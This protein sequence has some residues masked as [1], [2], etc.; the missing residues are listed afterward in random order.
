V[1]YIL[2]FLFIFIL[3]VIFIFLEAAAALKLTKLKP[4]QTKNLTDINQEQKE[5]HEIHE[6]INEE[7]KLPPIRTL[8]IED[9]IVLTTSKSPLIMA[10]IAGR[11]DEIKTLIQEQ[12]IEIRVEYVNQYDEI[13]CSA[14]FFVLDPERANCLQLLL[15]YGAGNE[16]KI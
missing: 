12:P 2:N 13:G 4:K 9:D 6:P 7:L 11:I 3:F 15:D 1:K 10:S 14:I 8:K 16:T 5:Q